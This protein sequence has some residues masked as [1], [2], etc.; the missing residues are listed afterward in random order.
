M[1]EGNGPN[2]VSLAEYNRWLIA[3]ENWNV[4]EDGRQTLAQIRDFR[5]A[6]RQDHLERGRERTE[7]SKTQRELALKKVSAFREHKKSRGN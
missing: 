6:V 1:V 2:G 7:L 5:R 4:A 3:E